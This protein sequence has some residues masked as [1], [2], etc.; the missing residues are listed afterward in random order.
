MKKY[1]AYIIKE[2]GEK[3]IFNTWNECRQK[4]ENYKFA[5]YRKFESEDEAKTFLQNP[6]FKQDTRF[7]YAYIQNY[8]GTIIKGFVQSWNECQDRIRECAN[9]KYRKFETLEQAN[10]YLEKDGK[11]NKIKYYIHLPENSLFCD[12]NIRKGKTFVKVVNENKKNV[13]DR[14]FNMEYMKLAKIKEV[15]ISDDNLLTLPYEKTINFAKLLALYTALATA[16]ENNPEITLIYCD[17]LVVID[18]WSLGKVNVADVDVH[19]LASETVYLR[20]M[21]EDRGGAVKWIKNWINPAILGNKTGHFARTV[22][23][24]T[25]MSIPLEDFLKMKI[26]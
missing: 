25:K 9:T 14:K 5:L 1:Y 8:N 23:H 21:F 22:S 11:I 18:A 24:K 17:S 16:L 6:N 12:G 3:G 26:K 19:N 7:Y 10:E 20:K 13:V 4:V 15:F 2:T